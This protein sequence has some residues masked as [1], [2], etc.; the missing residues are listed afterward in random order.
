MEAT[1]VP[2]LGPISAG[3]PRAS[4]GYEDRPID[5]QALLVPQPAATFFFRVAGDDLRADGI[6]A[7]AVLVVDRSRR[8]RPGRL[9]VVEQDGAFVVTRLD[10]EEH[11]VVG[12]V[13]ASIVQTG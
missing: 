9:A 2:Y 1:S 8:P 3:F 6:P 13:T 10:G 4:E 12:V 7:G 11:L 5:L